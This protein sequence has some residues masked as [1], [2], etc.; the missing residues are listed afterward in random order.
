MGV[1]TNCFSTVCP[2]LGNAD[3][4]RVNLCQRGESLWDT[5]SRGLSGMA[6]EHTVVTHTSIACSAARDR[7]LPITLG[8]LWM[9]WAFEGK[10]Q[11]EKKHRFCTRKQSI[12]HLCGAGRDEAQLDGLRLSGF[13]PSSA[14]YAGRREPEVWP[15]FS[16]LV[17]HMSHPK[18]DQL[19]YLCGGI[20][21]GK[22]WRV[23][24][25]ASWFEGR[26]QLCFVLGTGQIIWP[27]AVHA[28]PSFCVSACKNPHPASL[29]LHYPIYGAFV[30]YLMLLFLK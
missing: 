26:L 10:I 5:H 29:G 16:Q 25:G 13:G 12:K 2:Y 9:C 14:N 21:P 4:G 30:V 22:G 11:G 20:G 6:G 3:Q 8:W 23:F 17:R 15:P 24:A 7:E 19:V 28:C 18:E 1:R 27:L